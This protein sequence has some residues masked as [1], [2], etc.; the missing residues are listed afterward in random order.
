MDNLKL[1]EEIWKNNTREHEVDQALKKKDGLIWEQD[2]IV[3]VERR[4][5]ILNN[6]KIKK[7]ILQENHDSADVGHL[8]QQRMIELVKWNYWW[9]GLKEN[10][11]KYIQECF[12]CQQN[13][14]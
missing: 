1:Q 7:Q 8:G 9:P 3:Y 2:R 13:K 12:K 5:Y 11:K 6:K 14:V 10:I 4:I